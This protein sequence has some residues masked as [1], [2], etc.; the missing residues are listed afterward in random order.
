MTS[1]G[2]NR[3]IRNT[4]RTPLKCY[5]RPYTVPLARVREQATQLG[6]S[7]FAAFII[8]V[9]K[10]PFKERRI[11][12]RRLRSG[13]GGGRQ[14]QTR[15]IPTL[16]PPL[17]K[18]RG[19]SFR[20]SFCLDDEKDRPEKRARYII[21]PRRHV[22]VTSRD[23]GAVFGKAKDRV[24]ARTQHKRKRHAWGR[25]GSDAVLREERLAADEK[26]RV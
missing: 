21:I 20:A 23:G 3:K 17:R 14:G 18:G 9:H 16:T 1:S 19:R 2:K 22:T 6:P 5:T 15:R 25:R 8:A 4:I 13:G 7:T 11:D 10:K 12:S 24:E 26:G